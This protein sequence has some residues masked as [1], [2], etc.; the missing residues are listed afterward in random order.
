MIRTL[1]LTATLLLLVNCKKEHIQNRKST[2]ITNNH[3]KDTGT[4]KTD[5]SEQVADNAY[6]HSVQ[7]LVSSENDIINS[8]KSDYQIEKKKQCDLN[9]DGFNDIIMV[10]Q[11][12]GSFSPDDELT[13]DSPVYV[14]INNGKNQFQ[15]YR[16]KNIIYSFFPN[17]PAEGFTDLVIKDNFFTIE[18]I[19]G[20]GWLFVNSYTTFK[21]DKKTQK[22]VLSKYGKS[23][24]DRRNPEGVIPDQIYTSKNF[25]TVHF[26][27]F[28]AEELSLSMQ[29]STSH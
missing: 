12:L 22:I 28:N 27:D 19:E 16:N 5:P 7:N 4:T 6:A 13:M 20:G 8:L 17:S 9:G 21:F 15:V 23:Y 24:T 1:I 25:G 10:F 26:T 29:E 2:D 11:P 18:Q 3:K 14:L